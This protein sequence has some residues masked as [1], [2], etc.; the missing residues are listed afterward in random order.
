MKG[1]AFLLVL[2]IIFHT[3]Q[4][5]QFTL[6]HKIIE[7]MHLILMIDNAQSFTNAWISELWQNAGSANFNKLSSYLSDARNITETRILDMLFGQGSLFQRV[8]DYII[9][10]IFSR[11]LGI[12][13]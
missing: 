10:A 8:S 9:K 2:G 12:K 6:S 5:A 11:V 3:L 1:F 7:G 4:T 13:G